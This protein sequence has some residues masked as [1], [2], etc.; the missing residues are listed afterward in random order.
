MKMLS[1]NIRGLANRIKKK[2]IREIIK[3]HKIE[4]CCI[5]ETKIEAVNVW[6][7]KD[8]MGEGNFSWAEKGAEGRSGGILSV[9]NSNLFVCLSSWVFERGAD[10]QWLVGTG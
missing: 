9:W 2:E 7:C 3:K 10:C 6:D 8:I 4:F 1:L 5:Q